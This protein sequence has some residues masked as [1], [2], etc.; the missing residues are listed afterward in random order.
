MDCNMVN[1][2]FAMQ[3]IRSGV[4]QTFTLVDWQD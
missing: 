1:E 4:T 3:I 2:I